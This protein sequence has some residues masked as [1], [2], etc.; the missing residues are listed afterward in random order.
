MAVTWTRHAVRRRNRTHTHTH[1]Q[2]WVRCRRGGDRQQSF[3]TSLGGPQ[4]SFSHIRDGATITALRQNP[5]LHPKRPEQQ[6][7][8]QARVPF[9]RLSRNPG[10]LGRQVPSG[11]LVEASRFRAGTRAAALSLTAE[12]HGSHR[13]RLA[14]LHT[15][16]GPQFPHLQNGD[17]ETASHR[18]RW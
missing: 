9:P 2:I 8:E 13:A 18:R 1:T 17:H 15:P 4:G 16:S 6:D 3:D 5:C 12:A 10:W 14:S 11:S 7:S